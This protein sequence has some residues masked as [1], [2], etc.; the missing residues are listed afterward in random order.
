MDLQLALK[1]FELQRI[2]GLDL[3]SLKKKYRKLTLKYHPDKGGKTK[4]F[5]QLQA[6]YSFLQDCIKYPN[7][8]Q[9]NSQQGDSTD[10]EFYKQQIEELQKSNLRYQNIFNSQISIVNQF[11]KNLDRLNSQ[12]NDYS[13]NLS[14]LLDDELAK[15]DKKY[16]AGWWKGVIGIKSMSKNDL[17]YLQNQLINEHNELLAKSQNENVEL[18][19]KA[20]R[21]IVDQI[22]QRLNGF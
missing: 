22:V 7:T 4:D 12:S 5:V 20:Y 19:H 18:N 21:D 16:K 14:N 9:S 1:W 8:H 3:L 17:V 10:I 15:L 13:T 6:A 11:Y 2:D